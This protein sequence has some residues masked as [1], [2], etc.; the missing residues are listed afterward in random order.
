VV[1]DKGSAVLLVLEV[2]FVTLALVGVAFIHGPTA[3]ILGGLLGV[4][5][6]ERAMTQQA[7]AER[8][9]KGGQR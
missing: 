5:A 8:R 1:S 9:T 7:A 6:V 3:L 4:V 2:L